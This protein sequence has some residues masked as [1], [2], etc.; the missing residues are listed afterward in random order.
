MALLISSTAKKK[1]IIK[2]TD[3]D[4]KKVYAR[5]EFSFG[6]DG[7][8]VNAGLYIYTSKDAFKGK[9]PI[10]TVDLES[11]G[12]NFTVKEQSVDFAHQE[13]KKILTKQGFKVEIEL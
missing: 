9:S 13:L 1:L 4:V 7:K 11:S 2:G 6:P 8:S 12:Y 3:I 10:V 5:T